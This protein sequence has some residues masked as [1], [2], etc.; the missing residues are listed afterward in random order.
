MILEQEF[1][2]YLPTGIPL[3]S[4][5]SRSYYSRTSRQ[6]KGGWIHSFP[7]STLFL[8]VMPYQDIAPQQRILLLVS[9]FTT[10]LSQAAHHYPCCWM[11]LRQE[12]LSTAMWYFH[13]SFSV[14]IA[15]IPSLCFTRSKCS[16]FPAVITMWLQYSP[17]AHSD[18]QHLW[19]H[20][21][22]SLCWNT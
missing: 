5:N 12:I 4:A 11:G 16:S 6:S 2:C 10:P 18:F 9:N 3:S 13:L 1:A 7:A 19:N 14:L 15:H 17:F 8:I 20:I 22:N 21:F